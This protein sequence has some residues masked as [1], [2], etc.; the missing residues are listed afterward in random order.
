MVGTLLA[1]WVHSTSRRVFEVGI[2]VAGV[3]AGVNG[4]A[5]LW[6]LARR[7]A[8]FP[9]RPFAATILLGSV[10]LV[11]GFIL[12]VLATHFGVSPFRR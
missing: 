4:L 12:M 8:P 3:G 7:A 6:V 2:L 11:A 10:L 1:T 9:A 5:G